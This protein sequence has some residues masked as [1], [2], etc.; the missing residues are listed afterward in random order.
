MTETISLSPL[1]LALATLLV[2]A[3]GGVSLA[4]RLDLE[5]KL[6]IGAAR[7][8]IQLLLVGYV[9][10]Y[11][12]GN[13]SPWLLF[14]IVGVMVYAASRAAL[15]RVGKAYPGVGWDAFVTLALSGI[16]TTIAVTQCII[17]VTPWHDPRYIVPLLGMILGN[18]LTGVSLCLDSMLTQLRD[19]RDI[20][21]M[22]LAFGATRWEAA[23][24]CV[25]EAVR[26]AMIPTINAMSVVGIV[27]LPGMMTGQ[28]LAGNPPMEAVRYQIVVMFMIAAAG[29]AACMM[30]AL[31]AYRRLFTERHQLLPR[32]AEP[33]RPGA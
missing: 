4:L 26:R 10:R 22:E 30:A 18:S 19:R 28:I 21:E 14:P 32:P 15:E 7:T 31:F 11:V 6:A 29:A 3:A 13:A 33:Q 9:L 12:F 2:A 20:I 5:K 16:V 25:R 17:R 24:D 23:R 1:D 8:V 27:S